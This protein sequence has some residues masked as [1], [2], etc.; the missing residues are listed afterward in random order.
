MSANISVWRGPGVALLGDDVTKQTPGADPDRSPSPATDEQLLSSARQLQAVRNELDV[1]RLGLAYGLCSR[2]RVIQRLQAQIQAQAGSTLAPAAEKGLQRLRGN[3]HLTRHFLDRLLYL[4]GL[5]RRRL[6]L[7]PTSVS[8]LASAAL[9][10]LAQA[11]PHRK[12]ESSVEPGIVVLADLSLMTT[13]L[14]VLINNAWK[15][16]AKSKP[17]GISIGATRMQPGTIVYYVRDNGDGIDIDDCDRLFHL[18]DRVPLTRMDGSGLN[19]I[20]ARRIIERH[21]GRIWVDGVKG[22]GATFYFTLPEHRRPQVSTPAAANP[23]ARVRA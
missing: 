1:I 9:S 3:L 2:L 21:E 17:G 6:V 19:L 18:H 10:R 7:R 11:E 12:V 22:I 16:T 20:I 5:G 23:D 8:E 14:D 4:S 13:L 15:H